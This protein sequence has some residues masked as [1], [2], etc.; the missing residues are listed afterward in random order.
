M[1]APRSFAG[2]IKSYGIGVYP[3]RFNPQDAIQTLSKSKNPFQA[4]RSMRTVMNTGVMDALSDSW[5]AA[6][7]TDFLIQTGTGSGA[8]EIAVLRGIPVA[9]AYLVPMEPTRAFPSIFLPFRFS[10][11]AGYNLLTYTVVQRVL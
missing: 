9:F 2:W 7:D 6:Q 10:P 8:L 11:G 5:Q 4:L 1:A 3:V